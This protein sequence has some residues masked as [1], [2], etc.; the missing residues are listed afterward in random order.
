MI[1]L[2]FRDLADLSLSG[3]V[4]AQPLGEAVD[5]KKALCFEIIRDQW[6]ADPRLNEL[7]ILLLGGSPSLPEVTKNVIDGETT[8]RLGTAGRCSVAAPLPLPRVA[9]HL[10]SH[11]V[12]HD[13]AAD[14]QKVAVFLDED[15]FEPPLKHM[16]NA[17]M[18]LV[19]CLSINPV[20]LSH[21][22]R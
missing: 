2:T 18:S 6:T 1:S 14:Y 5:A 22:L 13:V 15:A 7:G 12:E 11:R 20:K 21:P 3:H 4:M 19:E 10:R 8:V 9:D 16:A 17:S